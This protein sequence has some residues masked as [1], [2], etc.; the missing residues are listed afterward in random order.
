MHVQGKE[1]VEEISSG[2]G[3]TESNQFRLVL[4]SVCGE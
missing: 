3:I 2:I 1:K 4:Y